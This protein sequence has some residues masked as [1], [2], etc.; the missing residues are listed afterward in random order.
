MVEQYYTLGSLPDKVVALLLYYENTT[1]FRDEESG[2]LVGR[3]VL[4]D[5]AAE[6]AHPMQ[7]NDDVYIVNEYFKFTSTVI[8]I[9]TS[10]SST[11]PMTKPSA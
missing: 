9:M 6:Q 4:Y 1:P 8:T 7:F 2:E 11:R 10:D 3:Q 5:R